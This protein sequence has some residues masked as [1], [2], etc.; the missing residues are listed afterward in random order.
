ML[1]LTAFGKKRGASLGIP[2]PQELSRLADGKQ[3]EILE[4][5]P[6]LLHCR[7]CGAIWSV[8]RLSDGTLPTD[9]WR[10][11]DK[12]NHRCGIDI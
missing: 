11:P 2:S 7:S 5:N 9:W 12:C 4:K 6:L 1:S 10:C 8:E 3:I